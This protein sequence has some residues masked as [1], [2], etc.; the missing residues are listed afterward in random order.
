MLTIQAPQKA[1]H[2]DYT[3]SD[4]LLRAVQEAHGAVDVVALTQLVERFGSACVHW[5][6]RRQRVTA[7]CSVSGEEYSKDA[8]ETLQDYYRELCFLETR[9]RFGTGGSSTAA[10]RALRGKRGE[11]APEPSSSSASASERD[12]AVVP[13]V[14]SWY[15]AVLSNKK[16]ALADSRLE[17]AAVAFNIGTCYAARGRRLVAS[18]TAGAAEFQAAGREF[19]LAAGYFAWL[20]RTPLHRLGDTMTPDLQT[21]VLKVLELC[22]LAN[23][24][25]CVLELAISSKKSLMNTSRI[26]AGAAELLCSV[27]VRLPEKYFPPLFVEVVDALQLYAS[28][29]AEFHCALDLDDEGSGNVAQL[30]A[31]GNDACVERLWRYHKAAQQAEAALR[32]SAVAHNAFL[33]ARC[34][35][36]PAAIESGNDHA[37]RRIRELPAV[38]STVLVSV[39]D[40]EALSTALGEGAA[41]RRRAVFH[42]RRSLPNQ[43]PLLALARIVPRELSLLAQK[44]RMVAGQRIGDEV[45]RLRQANAT[46]RDLRRTLNVAA[47]VDS[48]PPPKSNAAAKSKR[49]GEVPE[50]VRGSTLVKFRKLLQE[51]PDGDQDD[52]VMQTLARRCAAE[53]QRVE[54]WLREEERADANWSQAARVQNGHPESAVAQ[55]P[56][57]AALT[58]LR[59]QLAL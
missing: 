37:E 1:T 39:P 8:V 51:I 16:C 13:V 59:K 22:M 12:V 35:R 40:T 50:S 42:A 32:K 31:K 29:Q 6:A 24:Q 44:Y 15:D 14:F 41:A 36:L 19:Q 23:A 48:I 49:L 33:S 4:S 55:R 54:E 58:D 57:R 34:K 10:S 45:T 56:Y 17:K 25:L 3:L 38:G 52:E 26:A 5:Q 30:L 28:A 43:S 47:L 46:A 21:K 18:D 53:M 11:A 2:V 27:R 7:I 20:Q 9:F